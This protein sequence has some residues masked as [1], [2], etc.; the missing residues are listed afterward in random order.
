MNKP[1]AP[2]QQLFSLLGCPDEFNNFETRDRW[3][4]ILRDIQGE[5]K[6]DDE[7]FAAF[8]LFALRTDT[9]SA[10]YLRLAKNPAACLQ[11][12]LRECMKGFES[13]AIKRPS[14]KPRLVEI[15]LYD[16]NCPV[17]ECI[18]GLIRVD[19]RIVGAC[20]C[21]RVVKVTEEKADEIERVRKLP[22]KPKGA[23]Q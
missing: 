10:S 12:H 13:A 14:L 3:S 7:T 16:P 2:A 15:C 21:F 6:Y 4:L 23:Q 11:K 8:L 9:Y 19:L 22:H 18:G 5:S 17:R 20:K 1:K